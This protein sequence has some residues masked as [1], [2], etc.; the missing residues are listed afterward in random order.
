MG[1][2]ANPRAVVTGAGGG[3]GR[4]L[5]REIVRRGGRVVA[6]DV[7]LDAAR[8]TATALG[9][10]EIHAVRCDVARL[11]DVERLAAETDRLLGGV[12]L[13][14]N[15]AGV[16]VGGRLGEIPIGDWEWT[17]GINL[18]GPIY[19]CHVFTPRLRRQGRGHILNVASAAGLLAAPSMS[20]YN[21][22]KAGVVALSETLHAELAG[23]GIGVSVL[24]PTFFQTR[25]A[26]AARL[27]GDP[28]L[29]DL[30]R[31][32]MSRAKLQADDVARI[33][34]EG[35][36]RN[37]LYIL[38]HGDGRWMWRLKRLVPGAFHGLTPRL[39]ALRGRLAGRGA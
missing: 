3:L 35:V 23:E 11:A 30:V 17:V 34:L 22:T 9:G 29:L 24:C 15:N 39:L 32:L 38:P 7:D 12:D 5:C 6:S 28:E 21:V 26:D 4:A 18:W 10:A 2:A 36:A 14:V 25:I 13:V 27:S 37:R 16:A 33:A 31:G 20:P 1:L 19:G 8:A